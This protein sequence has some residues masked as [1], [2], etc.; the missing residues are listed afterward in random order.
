MESFKADADL[1]LKINS[2]V[3]QGHTGP[4]HVFGK[5]L[6]CSKRTMSRHIKCIN[7]LMQPFQVHLTYIKNLDSYQFNPQGSIIITISFQH[8]SS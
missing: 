5:S 2:M 4:A 8:I 1:I 6:G 7:Q 3:N